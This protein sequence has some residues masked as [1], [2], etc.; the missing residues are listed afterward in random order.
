[1]KFHE[2]K[3]QLEK[4]GWE[5]VRQT[6]SHVI[7]K[8]AGERLNITVPNHGTDDLKPGTLSSILK[9]AGIK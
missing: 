4:K 1:M 6:G 2:V 8:K 5:P 7:F 9:T 3:K